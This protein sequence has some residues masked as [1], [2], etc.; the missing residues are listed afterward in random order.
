MVGKT[1]GKGEENKPCCGSAATAAR[2]RAFPIL[3][4]LNFR[5]LLCFLLVQTI[6]LAVRP[7]PPVEE[8]NRMRRNLACTAATV[9]ASPAVAVVVS[10]VWYSASTSAMAACNTRFTAVG[11]VPKI[12]CQRT[13]VPLSGTPVKLGS[14]NWLPEVALPGN[15]SLLKLKPTSPENREIGGVTF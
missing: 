2:D 1:R 7:A 11:A 5:Y 4:F 13:A 3:Y 12:V 9:R 15:A 8:T 10:M 6:S 14:A